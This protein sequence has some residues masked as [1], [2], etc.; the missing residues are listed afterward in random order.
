MTQ[1]Q[2]LRRRI[3]ELSSALAGGTDGA[4]P[5]R[6]PDV[7]RT[8]AVTREALLQAQASYSE[9]LL[10]IRERQSASPCRAGSRATTASWNDVARGLAP[11]QALI[12]LSGE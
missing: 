11:D 10:Q 2:D 4:Q 12:E 8:T 9:L 6:G 7:A 1:E 5:V 3:A